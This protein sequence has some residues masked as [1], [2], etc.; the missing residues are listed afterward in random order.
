MQTGSLNAIA[1][2]RVRRLKANP[3]EGENKREL[4][5]VCGAAISSEQRELPASGF[6]VRSHS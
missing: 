1:F 4:S 2:K 3:S 6:E 5:G